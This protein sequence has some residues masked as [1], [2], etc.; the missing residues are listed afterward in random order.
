MK[1]L[2]ESRTSR[3]LHLSVVAV[4]IL[5]LFSCTKEQEEEITDRRG[6]LITSGFITNY[7]V[8][9]IQSFLKNYNVDINVDI[10]YDV[11]AFKIIYLTTAPD[12][13][14]TEASG[15]LMIP[16]A[17]SGFPAISFQHGT[18]T[19]RTL[20]ASE[21]P[22][23]TGEGVAGIVAASAGFVT[24]VPDYLGLGVSNILH[25]Y[26]HAG[27]SAGAVVDMLIAGET[28]C[29]KN[30]IILNHDLYIGG[31]SE[32]GYVTMAAQKEIESDKNFSFSLVASAPA[33]GPYDLYSTVTHFIDLDEY[34]EPAFMAYLFTAYND[35]YGWNRLNE[36]YKEP[37]A[38]M[39]PSLFDGTKTTSQISSELPVKVSDLF[40]DDLISLVNSGTKNEITDALQENTLLSWTPVTPTRLFHSNA[41]EVV[42]YQNSLTAFQTFKQNGAANIELITIDGLHHGNAAVPAFVGML[43]WFDSIRQE[44]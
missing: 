24:F 23:M 25:P 11:D 1:I 27:L 18:E 15:A 34:P 6:D 32:G 20:V 39:M 13:S 14:L 40:T 31:Y 12:G 19:K 16:K 42:P 33:A 36:I 8:G 26:L 9:L 41:D 2:P 30:D 43:E 37:Y 35:V 22:V 21:N 3:L 44:K 29:N 7:S 5:L 10:Q 4:F 38:G 28:F 17:T